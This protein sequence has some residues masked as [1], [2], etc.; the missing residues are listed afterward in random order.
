AI[1]DK[2][3][4]EVQ[5][6]KASMDLQAVTGDCAGLRKQNR[7]LQAR[8]KEALRK[9]QYRP[10]KTEDV[11]PEDSDE[12][13]EAELS[14]F[15]RRF[16]ILEEGP[17][18]LDI[19]ASNLSRDKRELEKKVKEL[20]EVIRNLSG[21][22]NTWKATC[23][24][25]DLQVQELS[26]Q[27]EKAVRNQALMEEQMKQKRRE[28]ELQVQEERAA[29]ESRIRQLEAEADSAREDADGMEKASTRL[30]QEL[31]KVHEQ[32]SRP[33]AHGEDAETEAAILRQP[34]EAEV[35]V[36]L[37]SELVVPS[38]IA[39]ALGAKDA[40]DTSEASR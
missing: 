6:R 19:L 1:R 33:P 9:A 37:R 27:M 30:T 25:K 34:A 17:A 20:Q 7:T 38:A 12:E 11:P 18:G 10:P 23:A 21:D 4:L 5:F 22:C 13:F 24:E 2:T 35:V 16:Q 28:I 3:K 26:S 32:Y 14:S 29:L 36:A 8:L 31:V 15:E 39:A 40:E